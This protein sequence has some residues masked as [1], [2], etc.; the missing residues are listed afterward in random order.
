MITV[1]HNYRNGPLKNGCR[2]YLVKKIYT[3]GA[4]MVLFVA[5]CYCSLTKI[6]FD[7]SYYLGPDYL[8][9]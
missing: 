1:T 2:K 7:Y 8:E 6:D 4:A 3:N 5:G 9:K